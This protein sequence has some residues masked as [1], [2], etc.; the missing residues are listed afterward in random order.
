MIEQLLGIQ[1]LQTSTHQRLSHFNATLPILIE[2]LKKTKPN[3]YLLMVGN[4]VLETKSLKNLQVGERYF[5]LMR[6]SSVG[7]LMLSSLKPEP[8]IPKGVLEL[9]WDEVTRLVQDHGA[10]RELQEYALD[11]MALAKTRDEFLAWGFYLLGM[12]REILSFWVEH[13]EKKTFM[14]IG[15]KKNGL[16]FYAMFPHLGE[17]NG[18]IYFCQK[19]DEMILELGVSYE[20]VASFL[21]EKQEELVGVGRLILHVRDKII[22]LFLPQEQLLDLKI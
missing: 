14:Q 2:V 18:R 19:E 21:R 4:Q 11:K 12:Q 6:H 16:V 8:K 17:M 13:Q 3:H 1:K 10:K 5:A 15:R 22:P 7:G 20:S 9:S